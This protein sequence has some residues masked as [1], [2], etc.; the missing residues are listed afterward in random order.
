MEDNEA[1]TTVFV[2]GD[3]FYFW[4]RISD[5]VY[6]I[7]SRDIGEIASVIAQSG[8]RGLE[9]KPLLPL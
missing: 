3:R 6:E 1:W 4:T 5:E 7:V 8:L 9:R 2:A